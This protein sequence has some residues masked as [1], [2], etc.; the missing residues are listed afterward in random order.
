MFAVQLKTLTENINPTKHRGEKGQ[1]EAQ[2]DRKTER[3]KDRQT[4]EL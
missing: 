4:D 1:M 2:R 3:E